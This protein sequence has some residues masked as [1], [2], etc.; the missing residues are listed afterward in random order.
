LPTIVVTESAE[1]NQS[2]PDYSAEEDTQTEE[3]T[4][5]SVADDRTEPDLATQVHHYL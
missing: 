1:I 2:L 3:Q 4:Q 5:S